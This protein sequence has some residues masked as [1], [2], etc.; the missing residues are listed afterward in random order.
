MNIDSEYKILVDLVDEKNLDFEFPNSSIEHAKYVISKI[1]DKTQ[2]TLIIYSRNLDNLIF[3]SENIL[4]SIKLN[5]KISIKI[6][7]D[8]KDQNLIKKYKSLNKKIKV[9]ISNSN[10]DG[11]YY[12]ISDNQR[13]RLCTKEKPH[14]ARVNFN[15]KPLGEKL[16]SNFNTV[17]RTSS[18]R[19]GTDSSSSESILCTSPI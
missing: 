6:L 14:Q 15:N 1:I 5:K 13:V 8:K 2:E 4:N 17:W 9:K 19:L 10:N 16:N 7:L 3:K 12:I 18:L 11:F